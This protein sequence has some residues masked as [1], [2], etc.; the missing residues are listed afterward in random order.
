M[1]VIRKENT[2]REFIINYADDIIDII[3]ES[4]EKTFK[5][6]RGYNLKSNSSTIL[7]NVGSAVYNKYPKM[8]QFNVLT[9]DDYIYI[10][11]E[12]MNTLVQILDDVTEEEL[13][14]CGI[15]FSIRSYPYRWY[16]TGRGLPRIYSI[17]CQTH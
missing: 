7:L 10:G 3:R 6:Y 11:R 14:E 4:L 5:E 2:L 1:I 12:C 9:N 13:R 8:V 15:Q 16:D 17:N